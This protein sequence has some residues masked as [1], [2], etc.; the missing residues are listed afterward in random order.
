MTEP[1]DDPGPAAGGAEPGYAEA[2]AE[3]ETI[4][5]ELEG[6]DID[7]DVL[8]DRVRRA[9]ELITICRRR[10]TRARTEV[11]RVVA[12]LEAEGG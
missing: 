4:L 2:A 11:E 5:A 1:N 12:D 6:D 7:V 9:S 8:A 3:L 10:I